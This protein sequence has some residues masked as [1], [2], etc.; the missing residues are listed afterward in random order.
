VENTAPRLR[1]TG[2]VSVICFDETAALS[3][4]ETV[5]TTDWRR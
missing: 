5:S 4:V 2:S 3:V 1:E